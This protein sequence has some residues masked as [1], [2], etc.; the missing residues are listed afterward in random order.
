[1]PPPRDSAV[2]SRPVTTQTYHTLMN[3]SVATRTS[4]RPFSGGFPAR[5][6]AA[7]ALALL[8]GLATEAFAAADGSVTLG[9][10]ANPEPDLAGYRLQYGTTSG[11]YPKSVDAGRATSATAEGLNQGTT[12]YFVVVAYNAAG[13]T[14][15]PSSVVSYTV[16]GTPNSAPT[17]T[18]FALVVAED[19]QVAAT[20]SGSDPESDP[21]SY[22]VVTAPAKGTLT[23]TAPNLTYR[24][25]ANAT[26]SDSFTYRTSDGALDSSAATVSIEITPVND[27]PVATA[28]SIATSEDLAVAVVLA[29]SDLEG[30]SL[31]YEVT[32]APTK[33]TLA[34]TPPNLSYRPAANVSGSDSFKFRVKD[35]ALLSAEATINL[36]I[37]AVNDLPVANARAA[38]TAED[39]PVA[40]TLTGTDVEGSSLTYLIGT[41]PAKGTLSGSPPN[42]IYTPALNAS[43]P[44][45]FTFQ[46]RDGAAN[47]APATVSLSVSA[48]NDVPVANAQTAT[49]AKNKAVAI[50]LTGTDV[51]GSA[52]TYTV[53]SSPAKGL[54]SGSAPNLTYT[55]NSGITGSDSFTFRVSDGALNSATATVS[56][57]VTSGNQTP[58]ALPKSLATMKNKAIAVELSGS[59][60]DANPLTFRV[61]GQPAT[62]SLS[63]TP[64]Q[65]VFKPGKGFVGNATFSYVA[66][67]GV[68]DSAIATVTVKVKASNK[69]PVATARTLTANQNANTAVILAGTDVDADPLTFSVIKQPRNGTLTGTPPN[70]IYRPNAGF[71][72]KDGFTFVAR[73]GVANSAAATVAISV[74]NPNNRAPVA[75]NWSVT[76]PMKTTVPVT[77]RASDADADPLS[78]RIVSKPAGGRLS[79]KVPNL[80]FKPKAKFFGTVSFSYIA[81]DGAV[82]ST[83]I[84]VVI[85]VTQPPEVAARSLL[86]FRDKAAGGVASMPEMSLRLDPA[87]PGVIHLDIT[88][89]PG[90]S[91]LLEHSPDLENWFAGQT[92]LIGDTGA[93]TLEVAAPAGANRGFYRLNGP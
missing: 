92:I 38:S 80:V 49:T 72:G 44:D 57:A 33:G 18:S 34:G 2:E 93:L 69:K 11:S 59:D 50:L 35:G 91:Y 79:G 65:L 21:L 19:S 86:N 45:S 40:V 42:V 89:L 20:L 75:A 61:V 82:D 37:T 13:V 1:M 63:G 30:D 58:Q 90:E 47:S 71:R 8:L 54:L 76:T 81:N 32:T 87:R 36:S 9:W 43:G 66:N 24:P 70:L 4:R 52:L 48:V 78:Y 53:L 51:E 6:S 12:Y 85:N 39:T 55:P 5:G 84:T 25:A 29:G 41:P 22:S 83:P 26:G 68:I 27:A 64:P 60:P 67:D 73:D 62:G 56:I 23:G 17:A 31:S 74:V 46:V 10:N 3:P 14:S 88:G 15:Q 28:K 7:A 16:P 77:L